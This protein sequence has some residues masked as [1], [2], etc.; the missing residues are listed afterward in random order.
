MLQFFRNFFK[1][2][3][4]VGI[5]M[6][7]LVLI[8]LA[9]ASG[10]VTSSGAFGG[11]AGGDRVATVG[12]ARIDTAD[13]QQGVTQAFEGAKQ[14]NPRLS[15]KAFVAGRS[16]DGVL[17]TLI[18]RTALAEFGE[19]NGVVAGE[20]L[21]G[22]ELAQIGAFKGADGRFNEAAYR[23]VLRQRG[24]SDQ[25]VR[26]DIAQ[27]LIAKQLLF[28]AEF[29]SAGS[30]LQA[31]TYADVLAAKRI[32]AIALLPAAVFAPK[33]LPGDSELAAYYATNRTRYIRPERRVV[34]YA[35][36]TDSALKTVPT[37]TEAE[38]LARFNLNKAAYAAS[39]NRRVTQLILPTEAAA[40]AVLAEVTGGKSLEAAAGTKGLSASSLGSVSKSG[41]SGAASRA[42]A[43][44]A[45]AGAAG[46]VAGPARSPLGWHLL[47][48]DAI[49]GKAAR[50]LEQVRGELVTQI[51]AEKRR[52]ALIDF[53]ARIEEEFEGGASLADIAK[54]LGVSIA[55]TA[56]IT[57]DGGIYGKPGEVAPPILARALQTAF[58]MESE[59]EPQIAEID[60]GKM[61]LVYDVRSITPSA[62]A[63][64]AEIKTDV[65]QDY[66]LA[67]G[68][69]AAKVAATRMQGQ[70]KQGTDIAAAMGSLGIAG[71]PPIDRV[72]MTR[73]DLGKF[74]KNTP[75]PLGLLFS[76]AKGTVKLLPAPRNRGWYVVQL[77]EVVPGVLTLKPGEL[78]AIAGQLGQTNGGEYG[79]QLRSA[80]LKQVGVKR[81]ET[82][83]TAVRTRMSGGN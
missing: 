58:A 65:A 77:S 20:R 54:Q 64:L 59:G 75:P 19:S 42:V 6:G 72:N 28:P 40:R 29:G 30:N 67:K 35:S 66:Q 45:F 80:I 69:A 4:G 5:T 7:F 22:S 51:A 16:F 15:L 50:A 34:R 70:I 21:V 57:G 52:E 13:L 44:A 81:N 39:E 37:P 62:P 24:L 27:G 76:M 33:A 78:A 25:T 68:A 74:G 14:D 56:P 73:E 48:V 3:I 47:R 1:S 43:D 60:P 38:I 12:K 71:L 2:R 53:T 23:Q 49:E 55:E 61:F 10:D 31:R 83:I 46:K 63:P 36:F 9:F 18:N 26:R 82:A 8:A 11:V 79:E 41:L 32:G 17:D